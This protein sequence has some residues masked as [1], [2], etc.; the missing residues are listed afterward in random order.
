[1]KTLLIGLF[2]P[3]TAIFLTDAITFESSGEWNLMFYF[4]MHRFTNGIHCKKG[5]CLC[6]SVLQ[7]A[8]L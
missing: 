7:A 1:M 8:V 2:L 6:G 3:H 4:F 5:N